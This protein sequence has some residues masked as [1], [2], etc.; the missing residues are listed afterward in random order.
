[1]NQSTEYI[2]VLYRIF[3]NDRRIISN[4]RGKRRM[5]ERVCDFTSE[6]RRYCR[7]VSL[8]GACIGRNSYRQ[9]RKIF[10]SFLRSWFK[11]PVR[12]STSIRK[13]LQ[14][15]SAWN[16]ESGIFQAARWRTPRP[17]LWLLRHITRKLRNV[18][19]VK[20]AAGSKE[21][22]NFVEKFL[23]SGL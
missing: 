4:S 5:T 6:R 19:Y 10:P 17:L 8:A 2:L 22:L 11:L 9:K 14:R 18:I 23:F 12:R 21:F 7:Y 1:M 3:R 13:I 15:D 16:S 20:G